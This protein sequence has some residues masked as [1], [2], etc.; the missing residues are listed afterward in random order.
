MWTNSQINAFERSSPQEN[1]GPHE[2]GWQ[3]NSE[4]YLL[5]DEPETPIHIQIRKILGA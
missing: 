1:L 3:I 2:G 5:Y 4:L